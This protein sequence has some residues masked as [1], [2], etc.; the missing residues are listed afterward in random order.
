MNRGYAGGLELSAPLGPFT[1]RADGS[2]RNAAD[3]NTPEGTL[4]N[5]SI[6]TINGSGG[7]SLVRPWGFLGAAASQYVSDYGIPPDPEGG[8]PS[9]VDINLDRRHSEIKGEYRPDV[10]AVQRIEAAFNHSVYFHQEFEASGDLGM[11]FGV[12]SDFITA[13]AFFKNSGA[14]KNGVIGVR[15]GTRDFASGGLT[16]TPNTFETAIAGFYYQEVQFNHFLL[17]GSLRYDIKDVNPEEERDSR[18]VG[19]IR[20]RTFGDVSAALSPHWLFNQ[21]WT[22]GATVMR[23]FRAPT[24]EELFSEGPHLAAYSYEVGNADLDK[25]NALGLELFLDYKV[26]ESFIRF[27]IYKNDIRNYTFPMNTGEKSWTRADLFVYKYVG[28]HALMRGAEISFHLPIFEYLHAAGSANYVWG[29]L[30][31]YH[32][33]IPYIP[34]LEGKINLGY[35]VGQFSLSA[36]MRL[37]SR[38][39]RV[40]EFE[41]STDGYAV[42]DLFAQHMLSTRRHL[43]SFSFTIEN[44][45]D[46]VYRKHLN[47]LRDVMPEPGRNFRLLYKIFI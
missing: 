6:Q 17:H 42:V 33:P 34:P 35:E 27:A 44:L 19:F 39:K 18:T 5:T 31:E 23:T 11:E 10:L 38:Q 46:A 13:Q 21:K 43:H 32:Q 20:R 37:A 15:G 40:G 25:E 2:Y 8:H 47:R 26:Q 36:A 16:F 41:Q 45:L 3:V 28:E 1:L 22:L 4:I 7:A 12:V 14:L 29:E 24:T 30:V 9:G